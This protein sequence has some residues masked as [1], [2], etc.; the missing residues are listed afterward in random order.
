MMILYAF[1]LFLWM[2]FS[3]DSAPISRTTRR[4]DLKPSAVGISSYIL[5]H[6][7]IPSPSS[8]S[9]SN[10]LTAYIQTSLHAD[11]IPGLLVTQK[12]INILDEAAALGQIK[13]KIQVVSFANPLGLSQ[14]VLG[15][16]I[17]RFSLDSGVNF[18]R[19]WPDVSTSVIKRIAGKLKEN[20]SDYNVNLIRKSILESVVEE[21]SSVK[22]DQVLKR[23]LYKMA[24]CADVFLDLHCD[25][26]DH[27]HLYYYN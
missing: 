2:V 27:F 10:Q 4:I 6:E 26:G 22:L 12:L 5:V 18:N 11:E 20:D 8:T 21:G 9:K 3:S 23:E 24:A 7:Y 14:F 16:H 17:G 25:S 15:S 1:T 19:D 13:Q